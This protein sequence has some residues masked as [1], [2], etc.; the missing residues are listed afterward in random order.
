MKQF[1]KYAVA[2]TLLTTVVMTGCGD[3]GT[4]TETTTNTDGGEETVEAMATT[5]VTGAELVKNLN[6]R[7][8]IAMG[9]NK[10]YIVSS[11]LNDG[12]LPADYIIPANFIYDENGKDFREDGGL[13]STYD[14]AK[15]Q[16]YWATA[17]N[18]LGFDTVTVKLSHYDNESD[19]KI[20]EYLKLELEQNLAGL[21]IEISAVPKQQ[22]IADVR[23]GN[24]EMTLSGWGP[25]YLDA[26]TFFDCWKTNNGYNDPHYTNT[27]YDEL[28]STSA[29]EPVLRWEN[30]IEAERILLEEDVPIVPVY[31]KS[32][33]VLQ[34]PEVKNIVFHPFGADYSF[35]WV[36]LDRDN[37]VLNLVTDTKPGSLDV[38]LVT[39]AETFQLM[40]GV[41]EGLVSLGPDGTSVIPGI[42]E[43]WDVD[44]LTYT[45]HLRQGASYVDYTGAVVGEVKAQDF[46]YSWDR[47]QNPDLAGPYSFMV[48]EVAHMES[49]E[50]VDDY[51]L[52]VTLTEETPWFLTLMSFGSFLPINEELLNQYGET[53]GTTAETTVYSGPF[54]LSE[55]KFAERY[56]MSKNTN[57]FDADSVK[58]DKVNM[59]IIEGLDN[60]TSVQMYFA[61]E[62][63]KTMLTAERVEQYAEHADAKVI[64]QPRMN[65]IGFNVA[66]Y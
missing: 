41:F 34:K 60:E 46:A 48:D 57:Y 20:A 35:Q 14:I 55:W 18:E 16:E 38:S 10:E 32:V 9:F 43:T 29:T 22:K 5:E 64:A 59:R 44:G 56:V 30:F 8:A 50:V 39:D 31:Q 19:K 49:Y 53:F 28:V 11:I 21:V 66:Q 37:K 36:E 40:N 54:Y 15:A 42:A 62:I 27:K 63:D 13:Y 58:I 33:T 23:A 51:T 26:S 24:F 47:L 52:K 45:F 65:Y 6:A 17:K 4:G 7:K 12:S 1:L 2:T 61:G 3:N 25:D